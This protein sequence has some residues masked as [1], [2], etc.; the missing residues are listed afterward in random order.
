[1]G[2]RGESGPGW[3][4]ITEV[5]PTRYRPL[6]VTGDF[7]TVRAVFGWGGGGTECSKCSGTTED[8]QGQELRVTRPRFI[9]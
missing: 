6:L 2:K 7:V 4:Q 1:M 8:W 9:S 5:G 3:P